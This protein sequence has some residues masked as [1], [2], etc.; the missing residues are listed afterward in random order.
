MIPFDEFEYFMKNFGE[1][2]NF[3]MD[4]EKIKM[5]LECA[6]PLDNNNNISVDVMTNNLMSWYTLKFKNEKKVKVK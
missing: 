2:E 1:S 3:Y 4:E 6:K 5:L